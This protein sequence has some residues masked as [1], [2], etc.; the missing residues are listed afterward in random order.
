MGPAIPG[1]QL[2]Q[3]LTLT[4]QVQ[5]HGWGHSWKSLHGSNF[6]STHIPFIPC[7][8]GIPFLSYYFF[9]L[10][11]WKSRVKVKWPW[12]CTTTGN[13]LSILCWTKFYTWK[14]FEG[15]AVQWPSKLIIHALEKCLLHQPRN[16]HLSDRLGYLTVN[17][18][19]H[20]CISKIDLTHCALVMTYGNI[21]VGQHRLR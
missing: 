10:W 19:L 14:V 3:N 1:I 9:K 5:G 21:D 6:Q 11:P 13:I 18:S 15:E 4:I 16:Q 8:S 7:Q 20:W 2:F 17:L 12:C